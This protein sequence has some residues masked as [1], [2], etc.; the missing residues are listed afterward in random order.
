MQSNHQNKK[1][2]ITSYWHQ[3]QNHIIPYL[4]QSDTLSQEV[5]A[6]DAQI[7]Q[8]VIHHCLHIET[9]IPTEYKPAPYWPLQ[10]S[11]TEQRAYY[12]HASQVGLE[13][14][15][16]GKV[17]A[18]TVAGGQG[19]RLGYDGPKGTLSVSSIAQ[20]SLFQIFAEQIYA[21][22]QKSDRS[23]AWYIMCSPLNIEATE[24]FF[25]DH[26]YFGLASE[27]VYF[28]T[29]GVLPAFDTAGKVL[30][31]DQDH[32]ALSPNGHG[33]SFKALIDAQAIQNMQERDVEHISYFQVDNPLVHIFDP[34]FIGLHH[35]EKSD[36]SSR[37]LSKTNAL[38]KLGN[39]VIMDGALHIIEYSDLPD[40]DAHQRE[41]DGRLSYRAGS[42]AIHMIRRDFIAKFASQDL[43]L[44]Y[45]KAVKKVSYLNSQGDIISPKTANALKAETFVFDALPLA[46]NPLILE[47]S[48]SEQFSPVKNKTGV[49]SLEQS[50]IDQNKRAHHW[51]T[52]LGY[53]VPDT[54]CIEIS[55]RSFPQCED[56]Q[57]TKIPNFIAGQRYYLENK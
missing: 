57:N 28:F 42:P 53:H 37:S 30:L 39:F 24:S 13:L 26:S 11:T 10:A 50:Q 17:A 16:Q 14:I 47:A 3:Q 27:D 7:V 23:I 1:Q 33:G 36:M 22:T 55:P 49:D 21:W 46:N 4:T 34:L 45:H 25:V 56:L 43:Q 31:K 51:L 9:Q 6:L 48:R 44:P 20:K 32:L 5:A 41:A 12:Q 19:T 29:Q 35:L 40:K 2:E 54:C 52:S 15:K 18:F 38:E 8:Q